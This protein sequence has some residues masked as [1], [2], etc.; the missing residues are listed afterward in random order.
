MTKKYYWLNKD[1]RKFLSR[2]YLLENETAEDRILQIAQSG[3][4]L[5]GEFGK[6]INFAEKFEEYMSL[7]YYSLSSP[8]WSNFGRERGLPIS[9]FGSLISDT[10]EEIAGNKLA[11]IAMMTKHGGGTSGYFGELRGRGAPIST[12]GESSGS[13]HFMELYEKMMSVVSQGNVRRLRLWYIRVYK[14][15]IY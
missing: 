4:K 1:S 12:G 13:V 3:E 2:G 14:F 8:I 15:S 5:L 7:G 9:C 11:E 10:L 6:R